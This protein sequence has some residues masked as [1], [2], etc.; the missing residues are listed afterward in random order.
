MGCASVLSKLVEAVDGIESHHELLGGEVIMMRMIEE[1]CPVCRQAKPINDSCPHGCID[2]VHDSGIKSVEEDYGL[3]RVI[4]IQD[5]TQE[6]G[7]TLGWILDEGSR[8]GLVKTGQC[9]VWQDW[10]SAT[11]LGLIGKTGSF[12]EALRL[13][14]FTRMLEQLNGEQ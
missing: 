11:G 2:P 1:P 6:G 8:L 13:L 3:W 5:P 10:Q 14:V 7:K 9:T 4:E 12:E